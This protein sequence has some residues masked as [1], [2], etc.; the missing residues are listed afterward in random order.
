MILITPII[1]TLMITSFVFIDNH[2]NRMSNRLAE[3]VVGE[4]AWLSDMVESSRWEYTDIQGYGR[5][6]LELGLN[7]KDKETLPAPYKDHGSWERIIRKSLSR[8]MDNKTE[9]EYRIAISSFKDDIFLKVQLE[10]GVLEFTIPVRR[11]FSSSAYIF[12]LWITISAFFL[13]SIAAIFMRNQIRPIRALAKAT[14]NYGKGRDTGNFKAYGAL[15]VR[16]AARA[17]LEMKDRISRQIS[18]RTVMLAGVSHDLRTPL[19][20]L[21]L[22]LSMLPPSKD[23]SDMKTDITDMEKMI[24][25][26]LDF[27]RGTDEQDPAIS[28]DITALISAI[29]DSTKRSAIEAE[30]TYAEGLNATIRPKS[31]ERAIVNIINNAHKYA[32]N[33]WVSATKT[34][35][36]TSPYIEI[37]IEDNGPGIEAQHYDDVF[38]PFF[39]VDDSRNTE[40]GGVGLGLSIAKDIINSHGGTIALSKST[41][42]GLSV[43]I[44]LPV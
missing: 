16:Q 6:H 10:Q 14:E 28:T 25:G 38:K 19:T 39:R 36:S 41:Y 43:S 29:E 24:D 9:R 42:G 4:V 23:V 12:L 2:W 33:I 30:F 3:S 40:T 5:T 37:N 8:A 26:Y 17:F 34:Q 21:K 7:Y 20:R 22:G 31:I 27:A 1:L 35:D 44:H 13:I 32:D 15:E 11:V 18:Q